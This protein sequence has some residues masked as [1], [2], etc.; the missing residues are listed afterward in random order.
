[1]LKKSL[2]LLLF[3]IIIGNPLFAQNRLF[4]G[5]TK[6]QA[7]NSLA[8]TKEWRQ[9]EM[10]K[11]FWPLVYDQLWMMGPAP[12]YRPLPGLAE[13]WETDDYKTWRFF[14][15]KSSKFS[16]Q[17]PVSLNDIIFSLNLFA[18]KSSEWNRRGI[19]IQDIKAGEN[20][21][22]RI[23]LK[24]AHA[25]PYP[26]FYGMPIFPRHI[27]K[28][29][30]H[31][32]SRNKNKQAIG[33]GPFIVKEFKPGEMLRLVK[34]RHYHG[35]PAKFDELVFLI[36]PNNNSLSSALKSGLIDLFGHKGIDPSRIREF[37][38][39]MGV[40]T[41]V[42]DGMELHWLS[43]NFAQNPA[44]RDIKVRKA[45]MTAIDK[46]QIVHQVFG[47]YAKE[48]DSFIYPEL[49]GYNSDLIA[50]KHDVNQAIDMLNDAGYV[51][52]D[53]DGVRDNPKS[54]RDLSFTL[55]VS[56]S[57][58]NQVRTAEYLKK[59]LSRIGI[60]I[61]LLRADIQLYKNYLH[62]PIESNHDIA[63]NSKA[64]GPY[65]DWIWNMM[66]SDENLLNQ[67]NVSS[68]VNHA[69]DR[70]L[71][72]LLTTGN[73]K[74]RLQYLNLAQEILADELPYGMLVRPYKICPVR[75][76]RIDEVVI[77]MG[78]VSSEINPWNYLQLNISD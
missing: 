18:D 37:D 9:K 55:L 53:G 61:S 71:K 52:I 54:I 2:I 34:N 67:A 10:G 65:Q 72:K 73:P 38:S 77:S 49:T 20:S 66:R 3:S 68:Y 70:I 51:D 17:I 19:E 13:R 11:I 76:D 58:R 63:V 62:N 31:S 47:G 32:L 25:G 56:K 40:K 39:A 15:N 21:V 8:F 78:G 42:T 5:F 46:K 30:Q 33:S 24:H 43:F 50:Y 6:T 48:I 35:Y 44:I 1:M 69:F 45:I 26:P 4:I 27:W 22:L 41:L 36:F 74:K 14:L 12:D 23:T 64:P 75:Q 29:Y 57:D 60:R 16:D 59:Q 28:K 7:I